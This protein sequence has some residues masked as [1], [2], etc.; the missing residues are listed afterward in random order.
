MTEEHSKKRT[1]PEASKAQLGASKSW[2]VH[3][4]EGASQGTKH[5]GGTN[6]RSLADW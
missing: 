1:K 3:S 2:S 6:I 4:R 5:G